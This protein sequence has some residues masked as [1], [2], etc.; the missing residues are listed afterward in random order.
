MDSMI[1]D[2][3]R[4]AK[5]DKE[6]EYWKKKLSGNLTLS[7]FPADYN[8]NEKKSEGSRKC[9]NFCLSPEASRNIVKLSKGSNY[10]IYVILLSGVNYLLYRYTKNEDII[11]GVPVFK[12][13]K[14]GKSKNGCLILRNS[15]KKGMSFR[16]LIA[17]IRMTVIEANENKDCPMDF[18]LK[19]GSDGEKEKVFN[20]AAGLA[21]LQGND[22]LEQ[23]PA[24]L[25]FNFRAAADKIHC[26]IFYN[27]RMY[28]EESIDQLGNYMLY[29][30]TDIMGN[31]RKLVEDINLI[32]G[33]ERRKIIA[34]FNDT[35]LEYDRSRTCQ[36]LFEEQ[37]VKNP[38][39][40]AVIFGDETISY[41][42]LNEKANRVA[43]VLREK[44][45]GRNQI[46]AIMLKRSIEMMIGILA[47]MKSGSAYMPLDPQYPKTRIDYMIKD[48]DTRLILT[49][50][51]LVTELGLELDGEVIDIQEALACE[52]DE[53]NLNVINQMDD[54]MY[55]IYTSGST[56]NPKGVVIKNSSVNN[57]I[58]GANQEIDYAPEKV[59]LCTTTICF[60]IFVLET[61]GPLS[62]GMTVV[63]SNEEQQIDP[64][65]M[66]KI[67]REK[68]VDMLQMTPSRMQLLL[69]REDTA[70]C[71]GGVKDIILAGEQFPLNLLEKM[72]SLTNA[73]IYN[74]YGPTEATVYS[75]I[76][77]L[78]NT[79]EITIGKPMANTQA[80]I[81]DEDNRVQPVGITGELCIGGEGVSRGYY[82]RE[83][84][85][86]EKFVDNPFRV[87]EKMYRTGDLARWCQNGEVECLGRIDNQVKIRGY[88]V[89]LEEIEYQLLKY[90]EVKEAA[91][92]V[93]NDEKND[94]FI[95]AFVVSET[96]QS[97]KELRKYLGEKLP[98]YMVPAGIIYMDELPKT[99]NGKIDKKPLYRIHPERMEQELEAK[100][101][102]AQLQDEIQLN[103]AL[104]CQKILKVRRVNPNE[105]FFEMGANSLRI[106]HMFNLIDKLYP[107][108][109]KVAEIF[110]NPTVAKLGAIIKERTEK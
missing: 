68:N 7:Q 76:K 100:E 20:V 84:L 65:A 9:L 62:N 51:R 14:N 8:V 97:G 57:L 11:L 83:K 19:E 41:G 110:A 52:K 77:R 67:I 10:L 95:Q 1:R 26:S 40:T 82:N 63:M 71:I 87:G 54:F 27:S 34:G 90:H 74:G 35:R 56:G 66:S 29:Y 2:D 80:Y 79:K 31:P 38:D 25:A 50:K 44:G 105:S 102:D 6:F 13:K 17:E 108:T 21:N 104:V 55:V 18:F 48:S 32:S 85:T 69:S 61:I 75:G 106:V 4:G 81:L 43:R 30:F 45:A 96:K 92:I 39:K 89:E 24:E 28:K 72:T 46:M 93:Q 59:I 16:E 70:G 64:I 15:V 88:R 49:D 36:E 73:E 99:P 94:P 47:I 37:A 33:D 109:I 78:T 98:E 42:E 101:T 103:I 5:A 23:V 58:Q 60:D 86:S 12:D 91:V 3:A 22:W 107:E 53:G